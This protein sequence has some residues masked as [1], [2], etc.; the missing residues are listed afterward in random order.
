MLTEC[1]VKDEKRVG[2]SDVWGAVSSEVRHGAGE[3]EREE[4][5][6][7]RVSTCREGGYTILR[8]VRFIVLITLSALCPPPKIWKFGK[9]KINK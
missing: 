4:R 1:D 6:Q 5:V 3:R 2:V 9:I 7:V 8:F